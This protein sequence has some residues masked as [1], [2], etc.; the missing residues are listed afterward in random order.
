[1]ILL[2][3]SVLVAAYRRKPPDGKESAAAVALRRMIGT[4]TAL[5]IPAI[6]LQEVLAGVQSK[7]QFKELHTN[8]TA[9]RILPATTEDHVKAAQLAAVCSAKRILCT[10]PA[11]LI[12]A[13]AVHGGWRLYTLD[14]E[15]A[16]IARLGGV[17][18]VG[19]RETASEG[20]TRK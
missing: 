17:Q 7:T 15:L 13:Q 5:G 2:D 10:P 19:T 9:F 16:A 12:A 8:L 14:R 4:G 1:M 11:A 20:H 6:V 18:L 3:A